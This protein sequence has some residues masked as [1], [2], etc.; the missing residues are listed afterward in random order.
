MEEWLYVI[1][2]HFSF[3]YIIV[4]VLLFFYYRA[5]LQRIDDT[6]VVMMAYGRDGEAWKQH[7]IKRYWQWPLKV[8]AAFAAYTFIC[9]Y[10]INAEPGTP[11]LVIGAWIMVFILIFVFIWPA[12]NCWKANKTFYELEAWR[13]AEVERRIAAG[14]ASSSDYYNH[15]QTVKRREYNRGYSDGS[16]NDWPEKI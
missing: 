10:V 5:P 3:D 9:F 11:L 7:L 15:M 16:S 13:E 14:I 8:I 12:I 1:G 2:K 4:P 6:A